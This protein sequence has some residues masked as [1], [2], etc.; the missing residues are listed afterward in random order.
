MLAHA[1]RR[2]LPVIIYID[3]GARRQGQAASTVR[4]ILGEVVVEQGSFI[5]PEVKVA[6]QK[7]PD[8]NL[9]LYIASVFIIHPIKVIISPSAVQV[10]V[11]DVEGKLLGPNL[12][13]WYGEVTDQQASSQVGKASQVAAQ[14]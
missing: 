8:P 7:S 6:G 10:H 5:V 13:P 9:G 14:R 4:V 11:V 3:Q 2:I 12:I 1:I